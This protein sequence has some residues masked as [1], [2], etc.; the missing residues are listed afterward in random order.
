MYETPGRLE[1]LMVAILRAGAYDISDVTVKDHLDETFPS[2]RLPSVR[3]LLE[4]FLVNAECT[5]W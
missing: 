5:R 4:G 3:L 2:R 1:V